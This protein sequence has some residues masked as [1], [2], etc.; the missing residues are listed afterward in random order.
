MPNRLEVVRLGGVN[1]YA[2]LCFRGPV[3]LENVTI[4]L[5]AV[6]REE[7]FSNLI[8]D[9]SEVPYIDSAALG[10][11]VSAYVSRRKLGRSLLL[12]GLSDRVLKMMKIT[13]IESLFVTF[14]TLEDAMGGL[15]QAGNA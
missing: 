10:G 11:L 2:V 8:L 5:S 14:P 1:G 15:A 12:A 6:K 4:F 9:F 13:N 3:I 7:S